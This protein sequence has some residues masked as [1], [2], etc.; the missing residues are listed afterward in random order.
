M[1]YLL[2]LLGFYLKL[3]IYYPI[4][5]MFNRSYILHHPNR[6]LPVSI[7]PPWNR[8]IHSFYLTSDMHNYL[9]LNSI[10]APRLRRWMGPKEIQQRVLEGWTLTSP[11][12]LDGELQGPLLRQGML[13]Y[14]GGHPIFIK[15]EIGRLPTRE[16]LIT[17]TSVAI[18]PNIKFPLFIPIR[19]ID[20]HGLHT[21]V[22]RTP[23][24]ETTPF[25]EL[26]AMFQR[27]RPTPTP[28]HNV[29]SIEHPPV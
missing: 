29:P 1:V 26:I 10:Q 4:G 27:I 21:E 6:P 19:H 11:I 15:E 17:T 23:F 9:I 24:Q 8:T 3:F 14:Q 5:Y 13:V 28:V 7:S 20:V 25:L 12:E 16:D 2:A 22:I 18:N